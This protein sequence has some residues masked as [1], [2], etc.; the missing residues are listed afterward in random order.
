MLVAGPVSSLGYYGRHVLAA[1]LPSGRQVI[2]VLALAAAVVVL[3][4]LPDNVTFTGE[5]VRLE[6]VDG[7]EDPDGHLAWIDDGS[8]VTM[9]FDVGP[10]TYHGLSVG[11][12]VQVS[13]SPRRRALNGI[14]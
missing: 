2:V 12:L 10:V 9:K 5:V 6:F 8:P 4:W 11:Q 1:A 14:S 13:W 3:L 7:G